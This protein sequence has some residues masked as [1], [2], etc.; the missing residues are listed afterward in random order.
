MTTF[1]W[2]FTQLDVL[3]SFEGLTDVVECMHWRLTASDGLG[4]TATAYGEQCAG[5]PDPNNFT[6]FASLSAGQVTGWVEAAMGDELGAVQAQL[7]GQL[8]EAA[9]PT[10]V[11]LPPPWL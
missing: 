2:Q 3:P 6:P 9:N 11:G 7:E 5:P 10:I 4:H 8:A 1:A